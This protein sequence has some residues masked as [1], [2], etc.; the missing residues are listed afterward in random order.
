MQGP[1]VDNASLCD[2]KW[3]QRAKPPDHTDGCVI[4]VAD[5]F[6]GCGGMTLGAIEALRRR[7]F[8]GQPVLAVDSTEAAIRVYRANFDV[9]ESV[10][11]C[12]DVNEA[13]PGTCADPIVQKPSVDL[14]LAG[15]PCQ[16]HSDL[17]N[18]TRRKDGRNALYLKVVRFAQLTSPSTIIIENVPGVRHSKE[19]VVSLAT[20]QLL[21]MGYRVHQLRIDATQMGLPQQRVRFFLVATTVDIDGEAL[22]AYSGSRRSTV[23]SYIGELVNEHTRHPDDMFRTPSGMSEANRKRANYL[24]ERDVYDL[25]DEERPPCHRDK[26]H[27]YRSVYGRMRWHK[28]AQTIT[29]G[30]GSM[31]QG[32]FL[33]PRRRTVITPHEAARL[34]GFPD[35]FDFSSV[36]KRTELHTMI[37]NAVPPRVVAVIVDNLLGAGWL[38]S[39]VGL[40]SA[41]E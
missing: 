19:Q 31:G 33:H 12:I 39:E 29:T 8:R 17:N 9:D 13:V 2:L 37:G 21:A 4:R 32:R 3:I 5:L 26:V 22:Q 36:T 23:G 6:A 24:F 27:S 10:A 7:G 20:D 28:P 16:G 11:K 25:P 35:F 34:Q 14:V 38:D 18:H 40:A 15:P 30:F 1:K 41:A